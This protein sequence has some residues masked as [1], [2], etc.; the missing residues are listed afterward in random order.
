[1]AAFR[2]RQLG[3]HPATALA[4]RGDHAPEGADLLIGQAG[5]GQRDAQVADHRRLLLGRMVEAGLFQFVLEVFVEAHQGR[6]VGRLL[7]VLL[8]LLPGPVVLGHLPFVGV[9]RH[10]LG[11]VQ[12]AEALVD[13]DRDDRLAQGDVV[14]LQPRALAAEQQADAASLRDL[15]GQVTGALTR[16]VDRQAVSRGRAVVA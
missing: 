13:R 5:A 12:G 7:Y 15:V 14:G 10:R 4:E 8:E 9:D 16:G 2:R 11:Q 3:Q 1:L 6:L